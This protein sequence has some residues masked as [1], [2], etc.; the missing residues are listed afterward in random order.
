MEMYL[1]NKYKKETMITLYSNM[2]VGTGNEIGDP[3]WSN[4]G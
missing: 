4:R 1:C 2:E 3:R